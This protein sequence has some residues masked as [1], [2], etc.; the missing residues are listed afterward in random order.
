[1]KRR[2]LIALTFGL[3]GCFAFAIAPSRLAAEDTPSVFQRDNIVAWCIVPFD[4]EK[5]GPAQRADMVQK[6]GITKVAYDWREEHV[7]Q[8]EQEILEYQK[9]GIEFFAFWNVHEDAL[10][11]FAKYDLHPQLWV[12]LKES[13]G[14]QDEKVKQAAEALLPVIADAAKIGCKVGI[15]N[16]GGWGGEPENMIAVCEYLRENH[17]ANNVGI[18]YNQHHGHSH[19]ERFAQSI[20]AMEP[21]LL[22]LNLNGMMPDGDQRGMKIQTLGHGDLDLSLL[23]IIAKSGY[24]GPIGIIGHTQDDV[25]LRLRDN[26]DGLEWL[27]S[28]LNGEPAAAKPEVRVPLDP[29]VTR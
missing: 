15:Y 6:L 9:R 29:N 16:H 3:L 22:C 26:L 23:K 27:A 2:P 4:S 24:Q 8:F 13:V 18:V 17:A 21:Y 5:R 11:L 25:E 10:R 12:M 1:M 28:Q 14:G 7:P 20:A 19:V